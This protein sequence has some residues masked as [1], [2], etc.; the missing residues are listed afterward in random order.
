MKTSWAIY[1]HPLLY[2]RYC[3]MI[4]S[5][6]ITNA[7]KLYAQNMITINQFLADI[8]REELVIMESE[9]LKYLRT[10][11]HNLP[12]IEKME[13]RTETND[14]DLS[15]QEFLLRVTPNSYR[16]IKTQRQYQETER[17]LTQI[18]LDLAWSEALRNRYNLL[19]DYITYKEM[20]AS[21]TDQ[22][23]L[24]EDKVF[25]LER[26]STLEGF[27]IL[28]LIAA[29]DELQENKQD[30]VDL[31]T[32]IVSI[33]R[34]M[35]SMNSTNMPV[36]LNTKKLIDVEYIALAL[37]NYM[38]ADN[39][40]H[41]LLQ[42]SS[43]ELYKNLLEYEWESSKYKFKIGY[44]QAQ[45]G[46]A[47]QNNFQESFSIGVGFDIPLK[48]SANLE[49]SK[50]NLQIIQTEGEYKKSIK[51]HEHLK[52]REFSKLKN[53]IQKHRLLKD[54]IN[55]S[56]AESVLEIYSKIA[57]ANPIALI[58]LREN[59]L[60]KEQQLVE[61]KSETI[62]TFIAYLDTI[63]RLGMKP[64]RNYLLKEQSIF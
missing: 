47:P 60:K 3:L 8:S 7:P 27:D 51:S 26:S 9:K 12:I 62:K 5:V 6:P 33:E 53:M 34:I 20:L 45:Y 29:K 48:R 36:R 23:V 42:V 37:N 19:V 35:A 50:Y 14:F 28:D 39:T 40:D 10:N 46:N 49:L 54:Q 24:Y 55:N 59:T 52:L 57:E 4:L 22:K 13:V 61:I 16:N 2:L 21:K 30:I 32:A 17:N 63:G 1:I 58:K 25:L 41:P 31:E 44:V 38:P 64:R 15:K 18:Q 43:A 56:D 11:N